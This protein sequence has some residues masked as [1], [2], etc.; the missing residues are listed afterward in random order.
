[1]VDFWAEWCGWCHR[2][3]KTTYVDPD[4]GEAR[5]RISSPSRST[6][7]A[8]R[9]RSR[10]RERYDVSSLPT[11]LFVS[12]GGRLVLRVN[13]FQGPGQVPAH[14]ERARGGP[15]KVMGYETALDKNPKDAAAL[16]SLGTHLF[17]QE[18]YEEARGLLYR[19]AKGDAGQP[20]DHEAADPDAAGHHPEL[21]SQVRRRRS[22]PEGSPRPSG[23]RARTRPSSSSSSAA[24]T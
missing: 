13:G 1:M 16:A 23:R 9:A 11:I 2:L 6:P 24:P 5:R 18:V 15:A 10:S 3:D 20:P 7:R 21:R 19:A 8:R 4:G 14:L 17:E 12:P 22:A